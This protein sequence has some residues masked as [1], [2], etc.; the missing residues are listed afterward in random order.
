M[1][2][3]RFIVL[4]L[5]ATSLAASSCGETPL[6]E[7]EIEQF[8]QLL[9]IEDAR[10][11]DDAVLTQAM[12]AAHVEVRRRAVMTIG[13]LA[14]ERGLALLEQARTD[15]TMAR[16]VAF[17][18]GQLRHESAITW[19]AGRLT[20]P[21]VPVD[22]QQEAARSLG[23]IRTPNARAALAAF[24]SEVTTPSAAVGEALLSMGRFTAHGEDLGPIRRW[25]GGETGVGPVLWQAAWA[26]Y[27]PRDPA[28]VPDLLRLSS[29]D[30]PEIRFWVMRGLAEPSDDITPVIDTPTRSARLREAVG[31]PDRR[32]RTEALRALAT[33]DDDDS[34]AIVVATLD[35]PDPW[36]SVSA[37]EA[38]ARYDSR[39][40]V[41]VP[42]LVAAANETESTWLRV[43][44]LAPL[45]SLAPETAIDLAASLT[46]APSFVARSAARQALGRLGEAGRA[47]LESLPVDPDVPNPAPS[48]AGRG[49]GGGRARGAGQGRGATPPDTLG[50]T[51]DDY[52]RIARRW[53]VGT[54]NGEPA[55]VAVW[56]TPRGTIEIELH[57]AD[58]PLALEYLIRAVESGDLV[59]TEFGRLVPN[60]VAQQ[61]TVQNAPR[62]RDEV[63]LLGLNRGTL[64]WASSGL[65]TGRPGYTLGHTPQPH[66]EGDFT[67]LGHVISGLDVVDRLELGDA[68]LAARMRRP[69]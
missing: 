37:A 11:F 51:I 31:D 2:S 47:R 18:Y 25:S 16:E 64:S 49:R 60:F 38:M 22:V 8:A 42:R 62:L 5:A 19:L 26:L 45:V 57:A 36:L 40:D 61:R 20:T 27:R 3:R 48:G 4:L 21:D 63:N 34:V 39:L 54:I 14:D 66:N 28:A 17:A 33:F 59:G 56:D 50:R 44:V 9:Q 58:A 65:D 52:R 69:D 35:S 32:V 30:D 1:P 46:E 67:A 29:H 55:P 10:T 43:A 41:V 53:I 68:I 12:T 24:L 13:R 6:G 23:K 7:P 15:A